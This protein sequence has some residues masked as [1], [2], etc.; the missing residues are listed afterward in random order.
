V[1]K[2]ASVMTLITLLIFT[3]TAGATVVCLVKA[4]PYI[5]PE[6]APQGYRIYGNGTYDVPNLRRDGDLYTLTGNINGTIVIE[7]NSMVLDG[8]GHALQGK[9]DSIGVWL[10][11]RNGVTI[12]NLNIRNFGQ[13]IRF[14][15]YA[16]DWHSGQTNPVYTTNCTIQSCNITNNHDGISFYWGISN[17]NILDNYVANNVNGIVFSGS[18]NTF[19]NNKI[20]GNQYDFWDQDEGDNDVDVSNTVNGKPIIYWV[21]KH[22]ATVPQNAGVVILKKCEGIRVQNLNLAGHGVGLTLYYTNN[23]KIIGNNITNNYWRGI[24]IWW[25]N[26]NSLTGNYITN[27]AN[28]GIE[29]YESHGNKVSNSLIKANKGSGIYHRYLVSNDVITSNQII[30]NQGGG[31]DGDATNCVITDNF[32]FEN[33]AAGISVD[34]NCIIARNNITSNGPKTSAF[35]GA[36]LSIFRN[37]CTILDNY[38]SKNNFGI[39][40]YWGKE[41]TIVGNTVAYN[42]N[43]GIRFQGPAENNLIYHNNFIENNGDDVQVTVNTH[44]NDP[45]YN[46][47]DNG[48]EGNYWSDYK[49]TPYIISDKNQDNHPLLTPMEF[50]PLESPSIPPLAIENTTPKNTDGTKTETQSDFPVLPIASIASAIVLASVGFVV[51]FKKRKRQQPE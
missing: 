25:S 21:D 30:A 16:P 2:T 26:N 50:A 17:C 28:D 6:Q 1:K 38:I 51:Y 9:G 22:N 34:S 35:Q 18:G 32:V 47:W 13:G 8:A 45:L 33:A 27:N 24:S 11:D 29:E 7:R 48:T 43:E 39:W 15:H 23:S 49:S 36:G 40:T 14:S 19:R 46:S 5:A 12:R 41:N 20:D 37:N 31:I 4:D 10:Q 44:F 3:L 42:N